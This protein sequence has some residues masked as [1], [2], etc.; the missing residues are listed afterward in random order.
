MK[1]ISI[2]IPLA[3][4]K[5]LEYSDS[6]KNQA[7]V[8]VI[9]EKGN[10]PSQNRNKGI[11]KSRSPFVAF[12]NAHT[13]LAPDW[14][15]QV[16]SFFEKHKS[17]DIV[18]GPQ[19]TSESEKG[20]A[21]TSGYALESAFGAA[22][23]AKRYAGKEIILDAS[24]SQLTSANLI[25]RKQVFKKVMFD[26]NIYPG[27]DPKFISDAKKAGFRVAFSP[28]IKVFNKRRSSVL[29]LARQIFSYGQTRPQKEPIYE[30]LKR[31]YFIVPS[32]FLV[33]LALLPTLSYM[34]IYFTLPLIAY[35]VLS[36]LFS[37]YQSIKKSDIKAVFVLPFIF[38]IIH[39]SYGVGFIYGSVKRLL[40]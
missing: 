26:E 10:N 21:K 7:G 38:F 25:C 4:S 18:G 27:E 6:I 37:L 5:D 22:A 11:K 9:I 34:H 32:L 31:P 39:I 13:S 14:A 33:Y 19:A 20:L 35:I 17:I 15:Q 1:S 29:E 8:K 3:P 28:N 12:I 24:E 23:V 16:R 30:T 40:S 36:I 2:V